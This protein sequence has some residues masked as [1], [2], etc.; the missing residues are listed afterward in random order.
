VSRYVHKNILHPRGI[1][2]R[3]GTLEYRFS[4]A[5]VEELR[6]KEKNLQPYFY[7]D[8]AGSP[9]NYA[10]NFADYAA[11]ASLAQPRQTPYLVPG[12]SFPMPQG[13]APQNSQIIWP[14]NVAQNF[15]PPAQNYIPPLNVN[16]SPRKVGRPARENPKKEIKEVRKE[17]A[18]PAASS[19]INEIQNR[20]NEEIISLLKETTGM[21]RDQLKVKDDQIKNLDDKIG[22][23]IERSRE[24]NILLKGL[25]DKMM[26]LEKPKKESVDA[27]CA[28]ADRVE[29]KS[30]IISESQAETVA[31][32]DNN[33]NHS[34]LKIRILP[35][36]EP[37]I[38]RDTDD[39]SDRKLPI[40]PA[41]WGIETNKSKRDEPEKKGL[42]GK[43]FG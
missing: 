9:P 15:N 13:Q 17:P 26:L 38:K 30:S 25:Q 42:F 8:E 3:Q 39:D 29:K 16:M 41:P 7:E 31:P 11:P 40:P 23:M 4:R 18:A 5:E 37:A 21:L 28:D 34:S 14:P 22:Q 43:I 2:S 1:K 27:G 20:G 35:V 19:K 32:K 10:A 12:M 24:M 6:E 36:D 33:A